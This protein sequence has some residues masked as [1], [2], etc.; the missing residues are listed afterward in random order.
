[1]ICEEGEV[2]AAHYVDPID[3]RVL[4]FDHI[5]Q[6]I[7]PEDVAEMPEARVTDFEKDR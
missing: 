1:L 6:L 3:N 4:G 7:V 2:D 5:K